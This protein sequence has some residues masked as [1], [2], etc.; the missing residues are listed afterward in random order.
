M[1]DLPLSTHRYFVQPVSTKLHLKN[2]LIKRIW[3]FLSQIQ[4]S[5]K[6]LPGL[7]LNLV[8]HDVRSTAGSNLRNIMLL[9]GKDSIEE[10]KERDVVDVEYAPVNQEDHWKIQMVMEVIDVR[11]GQLQL[12]NFS[13]EEIEDTLE[14]LCTS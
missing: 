7:L 11:D 12:E 2:L 4:K 1:F 3:S 14:Y 9:T 8:K 10:I 13:K 6:F 5:S